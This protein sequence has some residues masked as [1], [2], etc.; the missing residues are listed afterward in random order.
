[1]ESWLNAPLPHQK[2]EGT[3]LRAESTGKAGKALDLTQLRSD[4]ECR[5]AQRSSAK[6]GLWD[7]LRPG[8]PR[9]SGAT[10]R[11]QKQ[12]LPGPPSPVHGPTAFPAAHHTD[13]PLLPSFSGSPGPRQALPLARRKKSDRE[14]REGWHS[15]LGS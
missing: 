5:W 2:K 4:T 13:C 11:P 12:L 7:Q 3:E 9:T 10:K 1:M 8:N 15:L 6:L 14:I